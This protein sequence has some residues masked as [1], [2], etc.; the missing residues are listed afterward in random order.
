MERT[1]KKCGRIK[2]IEQFIKNDKCRYGFRHICIECDKERSKEYYKQICDKEEYKKRVSEYSKI[3]RQ[4][5]RYKEI[6]KSGR[7]KYHKTEKYK[8]YRKIGRYKEYQ[9]QYDK[10]EKRKK[11]KY[12]YNKK[13]Y[14]SDKGIEI[15]NKWRK[16]EN[17]IRHKLAS[18]KRYVEN[19]GNGYLV[20][21]I[22]KS[23]G[24]NTSL[25]KQ[26]PEL[27]DL[28]RVNLKLKRLTK[29]KQNDENSNRLEN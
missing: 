19:C 18:Y 16:T 25:I 23:T 1:C 22:K 29:N 21:M 15:K 6:S 9:K 13:Y 2:P 12:E 11:Y 3:Y 26:Y 10:G 14:K 17:G 27:I 20:N 28:Y 8:E 4:T 5:K 7:D 24:L